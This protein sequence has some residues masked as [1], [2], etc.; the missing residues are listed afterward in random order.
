MNRKSN[1]DRTTDRILGSLIIG[2]MIVAVVAVVA[3]YA[4]LAAGVVSTSVGV[5][6]QPGLGTLFVSFRI[7]LVIMI[8]AV[9][10]DFLMFLR[11]LSLS[12]L[13]AVAIVAL[14]TV[15]WIYLLYEA[16]FNIWNILPDTYE[17]QASFLFILA[18]LVGHFASS[19]D[20]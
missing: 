17:A 3:S 5:V 14:I 4:T 8:G 12:K 7:L 11:S 19:I 1:I 16:A 18:T 13:P 6:P 20:W 9:I 15:P 10:I 2:L